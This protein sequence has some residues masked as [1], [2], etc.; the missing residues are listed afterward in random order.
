MIYT[1]IESVPG[2]EISESL[3]VV[4]GSVVQSKHIGRDIMAYLKAFIGGELRGYTEMMRNR[5]LNDHLMH[6]FDPLHK[7]WATGCDN[8]IYVTS[9]RVKKRKLKDGN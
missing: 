2:Y 3:G 1:S 5:Q 4:T 7:D 9:T 8:F 6:L